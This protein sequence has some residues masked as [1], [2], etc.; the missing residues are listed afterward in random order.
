VAK[1]TPPP[2]FGHSGHVTRRTD[3]L[4]ATIGIS[5]GEAIEC[6][7]RVTGTAAF[8]FACQHHPVA[9]HDTLTPGPNNTYRWTHFRKAADADS[10][11]DVYTL[12]LSFLGATSYTFVMKHVDGTGTALSVLKDLDARSTTAADVFRSPITFF[13]T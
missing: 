6:E 1:T 9:T 8:A 5:T 10:S 3:A 7:L 11:P 13:T 12:V 2:D 4:V